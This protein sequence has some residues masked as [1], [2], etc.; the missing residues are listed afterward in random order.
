MNN[1]LNKVN[2]FFGQEKMHDYPELYR[3]SS[4]NNSLDYKLA[5]ARSSIIFDTNSGSNS[6]DWK[7]I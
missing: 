4:Y 2:Q 6:I 7:R 1:L 3:K 5:V